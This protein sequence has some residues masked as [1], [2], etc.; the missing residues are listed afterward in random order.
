MAEIKII[1]R[2]EEFSIPESRAFEIGE[3][4]EDIATLPEIIGWA[5]KPKFFKMARCFGEMLRA[6]GGRVT[7]KEVH[8]AMMADFESG[9][10]AAYFGALNSLLIVLMDGAPQGKGDAEE[11]K[12]DAS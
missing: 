3:R 5:R 6:A 12:P 2:G 7:D 8:S 11:G 9:K 1:F 4:I 10:P